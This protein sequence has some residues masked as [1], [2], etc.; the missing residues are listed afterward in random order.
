[1]VVGALEAGH[2]ASIRAGWGPCT[3]QATAV[4]SGPMSRRVLVTDRR[5]AVRR[6]RDLVRAGVTIQ[7]E[8]REYSVA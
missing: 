1:V 2:G 7:N 6:S 3:R 8:T 4:E 5:N